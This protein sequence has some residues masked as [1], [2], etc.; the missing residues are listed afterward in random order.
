MNFTAWCGRDINS[1]VIMSC[2]LRAELS[3]PNIEAPEN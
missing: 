3:E 1:L 2:G